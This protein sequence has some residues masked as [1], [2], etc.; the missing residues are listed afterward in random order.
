MTEINKSVS[1][2]LAVAALTLGWLVSGCGHQNPLIGNWAGTITSPQGIAIQSRL[3]LTADGKDTASGQFSGPIGNNRIDANGTYT[4]SGDT[5]TQTYTTLT[6]NGN[7]VPQSKGPIPEQS[8]FK[9]DGDT[10]TL[11][12]QKTGKTTVLIRQK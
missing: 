11:T 1:R 5:I 8:T 2:G 7:P 9:I 10:L 3:T 12:S 6:V 4:V